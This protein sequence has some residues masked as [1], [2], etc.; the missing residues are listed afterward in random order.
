MTSTRRWTIAAALLLAAGCAG[1]SR[2]P[3]API[4]QDAPGGD[5]QLGGSARQ[6]DSSHTALALFTITV[7][8]AAQLGVAQL[9]ETR[10]G[11]QTDDVYELAIGNFITSDTLRVES[12]ETTG[13]A[14]ELHYSV[15]HPFKAPTELDSAPSASNRAD[16]AV[17][18]RVAFLIDVEDPAGNRFFSGDGEV[19]VNTDL[20]ANADGYYSPGGLLNLTGFTANTFPYKVLVDETLDPRVGQSDGLPRSNGGSA[21]GNYDPLTGWQRDTLG[22]RFDG[23][24]GYGVMHHGQTVYNTLTLN[25]DPLLAGERFAFDAAIIVKYEDPRGGLNANE[26][27]G[28]RLPPATPDLAKFVYREPHGALDIER[29]A[30]E[31]EGGTFLTNQV[32]GN[33]LRFRV[34]DWDARATTTT[35]P[36]LSQDLSSASTVAQ[37]EAGAPTLAVCIPGVLGDA[38]TV[39]TLTAAALTDN[40][41]QVGGDPSADSGVPGDAL[42][43]KETISKT[44]LSGQTAGTYVGLVRAI[45][46]E[47][48][49][50]SVLPLQ[51]DLAPVTVNLPRPV[52]YQKFVVNMGG[53]GS[54]NL[55]P[56]LLLTT[57]VNVA[58]GETTSISVGSYN[59]SD[60]DQIIVECDWDSDG[61]YEDVEMLNGGSGGG[62]VW[63]SPIT[64]SNPTSQIQTRT[65][66]VR[67]SDGVIT[68]PLTYNP[69]LTFLLGPNLAPSAGSLALST[70]ATVFSGST[71]ML[72][73]LAADDPE[74]DPITLFIDWD[75]LSATPAEQRTLVAPYPP[76]VFTSPITY[77]ATSPNE[78]R[79]I[80][81]T[82]KDPSHAAVSYAPALSFNLVQII[83]GLPSVSLTTPANIQSATTTTIQVTS[84]TD[85][86]GNPIQFAIDWDNHPGT[87]ADI[88]TL[89]APYSTPVV[90]TSP[91]P[92]INT[93]LSNSQ[94]TI[95]V[96]V[97]DGIN[98]AV[99]YSP[100]L[101]F[102]L[103]P[104]R[105]PAVSGSRALATTLLPSPATFTMNAGSGT[106]S[107][108]EG[109]PIAYAITN[110]VNASTWTGT[111]F[112]IGNLGPFTSPTTS[113]VF[114]VYA[115]DALHAGTAGAAYPTVTGQLLC[116][117]GAL[118][119]SANFNAG[120]NGF[121][122][123]QS[124]APQLP[125]NDFTLESS[126]ARCTTMAYMG[127]AFSGMCLTTGPDVGNCGVNISAYGQQ[128][129]NNVVSQPFSLAG[130]T[131]ARLVFDSVRN[132]RPGI[133]GGQYRVYATTNGSSWTL[134]DQDTSAAI[135][136]Y[137]TDYEVS[138]AS[139]AGAAT[140]RL[141]FEFADPATSSTFSGIAGRYAG[142]SIDNVEVYA[143][144]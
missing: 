101:S 99:A 35:F 109:D 10:T 30:F 138:L 41:S 94:R 9:K 89:N 3:L 125:N 60:G 29:I 86:D 120:M 14:V 98:P 70:P 31:G 79:Q 91:A 61:S 36:D 95:P 140:V 117:A 118:V 28:N 122:L 11:Q 57:P 114:T 103:G 66:P 1:A 12:V 23:W 75:N 43:Y 13:H 25:R 26:K 15:T 38:S 139:V 132:G 73:V 112:P 34:V 104:N 92:Y 50:S 76:T 106:A 102:Q 127:A 21:T 17:S 115:T 59:D 93:T 67:F 133:T 119:W 141:R 116:N 131:N 2:S 136:E 45:D 64:Y 71:T 72:S 44:V 129:E 47:D 24:T 55:L 80:P 110:N 49:T 108:P 81:V 39:V 56:S 126:F 100:S 88:R 78:V 143:C 107:D 32:S 46:V 18:G 84:A 58:S 87:P 82:Y 135:P 8:P 142:W 16:L 128:L 130:R 113:V 111:T 33:E 4:G 5:V 68:S 85:P 144:P 22:P 48:G 40:D 20:V 121:V 37:G 69:S 123:G 65:I 6:G 90:Y 54:D 51:E 134:L 19:I 7:D 77:T 83:G 42:Y 52:A 105:P 137:L 97:T 63:T 27:R 96:T 62:Q 124:Y 74:G 53:S